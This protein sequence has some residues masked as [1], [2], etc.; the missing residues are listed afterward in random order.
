ML[1]GMS[2]R[3]ALERMSVWML[4]LAVYLVGF[5][6]YDFELLSPNALT[7]IFEV[8][9]CLSIPLFVL[10]N[11]AIN[12]KKRRALGRRHAQEEIGNTG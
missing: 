1:M 12:R 9:V 7:L 3:E 4:A 5:A 6:L 10:H 11:L 8:T 2:G